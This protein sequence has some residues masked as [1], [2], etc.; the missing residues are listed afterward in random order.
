[1]RADL[2]ASATQVADAVRDTLGSARF[3]LL[4]YSLGAR[5][6]LHVMT[7]TDLAPAVD[8]V[9]FIGVTAGMED[10]AERERRRRADEASADELEAS[11]D[12]G[13]FVDDWLAG[14]LF[15]RLAGAAERAERGR[16]TAS[17]LASSLR[18]CGTGTQEPL[19][20]RLG[21]V[22][23]PVLALAGMDDAALRR[24]RAAGGPARAAWRGV[25]G[26]RGRPR[27]P[28]GPAR[29]DRA[30]GRALAQRRGR[31][32]TQLRRAGRWSATRPPRSAGGR[33]SRA[34][35][36]GP[37]PP[38]PPRPTPAARGPAARRPGPAEP[39]RCSAP[40]CRRRPPRP[41]GSG[42]KE[43]PHP[44]GPAGQPASAC[45]IR[46]RWRCRAGCW[47]AAAPPPA[48]RPA[49]RPR[50]RSAQLKEYE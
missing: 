9:V 22:S 35:A 17:G 26:A 18:L 8:H 15:E 16:N 28:P 47:P 36:T 14:P 40:G 7:G 33:S 38:G 19:W 32:L 46:Y 6:A 42:S 10:P 23:T 50:A 49:R 4:G 45:R 21:T 29:P 1:M 2:P 25:A 20:D 48:G 41:S 12:V 39:R 31:E 24:A 43:C 34:A 5:V 27:R 11:G 44:G 13:R 37:V 3:D 30:A